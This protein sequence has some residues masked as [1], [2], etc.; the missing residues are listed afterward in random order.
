VK[1]HCK[2]EE[3]DVQPRMSI[4]NVFTLLG[5]IAMFLYGM[6]LM[7]KSLEQTAGSKLQGILSKMTASPLKGLLLGCVVTAVIQSSG[8]TTVM[9][10]GFVNSGLMELHQAI[11][12]IMGANV[13]TTVTGWLLSLSGLEGDSFLTQMLNPDAW[14]PI[15]GFAGIVLYMV[16]KDRKR[17]IGKILL[18]FAILM[19]GMGIM[20]DAMAPLAEEAWFMDLFL[21]FSNPVFGVIAGAVLTAVL[22]SSSAA[23]GIL[24]ALSATGAVSFAAALPIIM[25]QNIGTTTTA[26]ISSTGA[27]KNA[28]RTAFV[29]FYFNVIGTAVFLIGFYA[30][31]A[32]FHFA[33]FNQP[34]NTFG[35]A[36]VHTAFNLITT[37]VLLPF[38]RV[39]E[40]LAIMTVPDDPQEGKEQH[41]L[42]DD[43]LLSTP[44]V[45]VGR[46][47]LTGG[48]MAE[49][50][51][52]ALL[53][54]MST[55]RK[56]DD[57][58]AKE[59]ARKED[60][61][62]HYEDVLGTYLVK[63]SAKR[64]SHEDQRTVNT[65]LHTINDFERISD[66]SMNLVKT[67]Q[68]I[69]DKD[70]QFSHEALEDL[71]V[72][73]AAVQDIVNR[74]VDA[75]QKNDCYAAG[76]VEP[77]EQVVDGLVREVKTRHIA[78]LQAGDCTIEYGFVLDDLLTSYERIADH[79]S[80]VAVAMIEVAADKFDTHE[81]LNTVKHGGS[82][83]F[84]QRYEK[85]RDRYTFAE[86]EQPIKG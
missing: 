9:A 82:A 81:Y 12:V 46:A 4:F 67:A 7:G 40:R 62:D 57:T 61:V 79:C 77:L 28:R 69:R 17:G 56:W 19:T 83:K 60:A 36:I 6:D 71:S 23:V 72:L 59:V 53:Q 58:I 73:E 49:I 63:L 44:S 84:E 30:L 13:G 8:A 5:G 41:S 10:V 21:S 86:N 75:F 50:C 43:R 32:M 18:G 74:T 24:Q 38:N 34:A 80:N 37:A 11:G 39:L 27:N 68:E 48:D 47:M 2:K 14:A 1:N 64:L 35:I 66:H 26:V 85:Y 52:V 70:I 22:Q 33:F 31:N 78:R 45:A 25:G 29:H 65:L 16:G 51:R 76:K 3:E 20:S 54:A 42:L 55:T 15:L